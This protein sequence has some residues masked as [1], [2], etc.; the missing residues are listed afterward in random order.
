MPRRNKP[1][2]GDNGQGD[3]FGHTGEDRA[4][5]E[6][7]VIAHTDPEYVLRWHWV[8][9]RIVGHAGFRGIAS[10]MITGIIGRPTRGGRPVRGK[11]SN[12]VPALMNACV[13]RHPG[14]I[15]IGTIKS[16]YNLQTRGRDKRHGH[17]L[18]IWG[19]PQQEALFKADRG[20]F[21]AG[22]WEWWH[23]CFAP[24]SKLPRG[25]EVDLEI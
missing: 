9:D 25:V 6:A 12:A 18:R 5:A 8:G 14:L 19:Y 20:A 22:F 21:K 1:G 16:P 7:R 23:E 11:H 10:Q 2:G 13:R 4:A 15:K 24:G 17:E 3:L